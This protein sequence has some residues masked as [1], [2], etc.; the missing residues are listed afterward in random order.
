[1]L[2]LFKAKS[3]MNS[4]VILVV[5]ISPLTFQCYYKY[6]TGSCDLTETKCIG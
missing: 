3:F 1:M 6:R 2:V 4:T 5:D